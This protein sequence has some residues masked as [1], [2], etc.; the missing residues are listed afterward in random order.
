MAVN[1][2]IQ[3]VDYGLTQALTPI[4]GAPIVSPRKK[5][6]TGRNPTTSDFAQ[7]G[8]IWVNSTANAAFILTSIVGNIANWSAVGGGAGV[9]TS[10]A[11]PESNHRGKLDVSSR[12]TSRL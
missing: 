5:F 8:T 2:K 1:N 6:Q 7:L 11:L 3:F 12:R 4:P 10:I 9:F